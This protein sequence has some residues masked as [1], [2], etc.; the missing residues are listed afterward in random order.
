MCVEGDF[1]SDEQSIE[2]I[3]NQLLENRPEEEQEQ[4]KSQ[5]SENSSKTHAYELQNYQCESSVNSEVQI[6]F[7]PN[8]T[9]IRNNLMRS[10]NN[11]HVNGNPYN[12]A[13]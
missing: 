7:V 12:R 11:S 3:D 2:D 10:V 5:K 1:Q 6:R 4:Q 9:L 8:S 13:Y